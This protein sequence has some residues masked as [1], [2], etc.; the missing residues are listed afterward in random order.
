MLKERKEKQCLLDPLQP[1]RLG[2]LAHPWQAWVPLLNE[3]GVNTA[4]LSAPDGTPWEGLHCA[5]S[6]WDKRPVWHQGLNEFQD[7]I[8]PLCISPVLGIPA[9]ASLLRGEPPSI[10][11]P[12]GVYCGARTHWSG[13]G[14]CVLL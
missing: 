12:A 8:Q 5:R 6:G 7:K 9:E 13:R 14:I 10:S 11:A 3:G 2:V 4:G 1:P